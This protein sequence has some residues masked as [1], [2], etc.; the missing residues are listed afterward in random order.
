MSSTESL[1]AGLLA[2]LFSLG[3]LV[4]AAVWVARRERP[5]DLIL[6]TALQGPIIAVVVLP[7]ALGRPW[8]LAAVLGLSGLQAL[9]LL[10]SLP[11]RWRALALVPPACASA[12]LGLP[13][14]PDLLAD[15]AFVYAAIEVHDAFAFVVGKAVGRRPMAPRLSPRKTWEGEIGGLLVAASVG[16]ITGP[17]LLGT[18]AAAGCGLAVVLALLG[19]AADLAAS[20]V[21]RRHGLRAFAG[22]IPLH[23]S[24]SD[25]YDSWILTAPAAV[26]LLHATQ[27]LRT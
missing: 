4:I 6:A 23:H 25:V 22:W 26:A 21:K 2:V 5:H 18:S 7:A 10:R 27:G 15:V 19:L 17:A 13:V 1:I 9:E 12:F 16:A 8:F 24:L 20:W 14:G 3:G 11:G